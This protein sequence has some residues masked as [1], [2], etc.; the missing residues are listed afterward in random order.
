MDTTTFT[1]TG[2]ANCML[3]S[4]QCKS[5]ARVVQKYSNVETSIRMRLLNSLALNEPIRFSS[6]KPGWCNPLSCA[7]NRRGRLSWTSFISTCANVMKHSCCQCHRKMTTSSL[8]IHSKAMNND[9]WKRSEIINLWTSETIF[10]NY[11][12]G[13]WRQLGGSN[14]EGLA[15]WRKKASVR[16]LASKISVG[17]PASPAGP[18][19][20]LPKTFPDVAT[21]Y[22]PSGAAWERQLA[23]PHCLA[24]KPNM[25]IQTTY[26]SCGY[27]R[28]LL[29]A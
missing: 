19:Q 28:R 17:K 25:C 11:V 13:G 6:K 10:T 16:S 26:P 3:V 21:S 27:Y 12:L 5:G 9:S 18:E 15:E 4:C 8:D 29:A 20:G 23:C 14:W 1:W 2:M 7:H 22:H 24:S